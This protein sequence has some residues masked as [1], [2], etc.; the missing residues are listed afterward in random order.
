M[1]ASET[2]S[3]FIGLFTGALAMVI[4]IWTMRAR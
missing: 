1:L 2:T 4:V 3:F